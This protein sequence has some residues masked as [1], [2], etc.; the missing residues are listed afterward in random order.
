[1]LYVESFQ[2]LIN[3]SLLKFVEPFE[4]RKFDMLKVVL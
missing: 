4:T 1:M 3:R 2:V